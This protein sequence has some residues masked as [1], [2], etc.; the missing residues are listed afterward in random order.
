MVDDVFAAGE[1][2]ADP[3]GPPP[4]RY[5]SRELSWIAFNERVLAEARNPRQP[6]LER[7]RFAAIAASNLDE[8]FMI[9]VSGL[10]QQVA[11]GA[12]LV[13]ADGRTPRQ[14]LTAVA[15]ALRTH[16]AVQERALVGDLLPALAGVGIRVVDHADLAASARGA[17]ARYAETALLPSC[18]PVYFDDGAPYPLVPGLSLCL[19]VLVRPPDGGSRLAYVALPP[20]VERFVGVPAGERCGA[21]TFTWLEQVLLAHLGALFPGQRILEAAPFRLLRDAELEIQRLEA[22][23]LLEHVDASVRQRPYQAVVALFTSATMSASLR[24]R[25]ATALGLPAAQRWVARGPLRLADLY[26]LARLPRADLKHTPFVPRVP[27]A[28]GTGT[29]P[30]AAIRR[31]DILLHHPFD[32]FAVVADLIDRAADDPR[33]VAIK[34]TLYRVGEQAPVVAALRRAAAAGKAV[35]VAVELTARFDEA[36]NLE[37]GRALERA[38]AQVIYGAPGLKTHAKLALIERREEGTLRRYVHLSS[39]NYNPLTAREYTD[40]GLLTCD[41]GIAADAAALFEAAAG[42]PQQPAYRR[43]LV[44]PTTLRDGLL[45]RIAREIRHQRRGRRGHLIFKLN[46]LADRDL[47]DALY[48]ASRAG[49]TVD[50]LV[51]GICCL[52]PGVPGVSA[53]VRV[54]SIVGRFLEHSRVYYFGNGGHPD[55]LIGSADLMP[56]NLDR[57]VEVLTPIRSPSLRRRLRAT[58][59]IYL[60][61]NLQSW[62]MQA[63]GTYR[64]RRPALGEAPIDAQSRLLLAPPDG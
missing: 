14:Q 26:Q 41:E 2:S 47:I 18:T 27:A 4:D 59:V 7:V 55:V 10:Q 38:G 20:T 56:R 13:G 22:P 50:L 64:R 28:L 44:A 58:L 37:W 8:Y 5:L 24:G 11:S 29:D 12:R 54:V 17:L 48:A 49:V 15:A 9:R 23:D 53:N 33:V 61:D 1:P 63:D 6:P 46:A 40:L 19:A 34:Q 62:E 45:R 32:D 42:R 30:F 16:L 25:L 60:D 3:S 51:R 31:G 21:W 36:N 52:R 39:G 35:T 43:L 57:R